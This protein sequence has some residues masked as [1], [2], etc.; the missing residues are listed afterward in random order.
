MVITLKYIGSN[1]TGLTVN[2]EYIALAVVLDSPQP[3]AIILNDLG[4]PYVTFRINDTAEWQVVSVKY[5]GCVS[6]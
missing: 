1:E 5:T 3:K 2:Q 4:V 6:I